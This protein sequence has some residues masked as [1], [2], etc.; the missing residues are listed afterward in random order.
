MKKNNS[1]PV[2][3][4]TLV[5]RIL[6]FVRSGLTVWLFPVS[7]VSDQLNAVLA[8]PNGFRKLLAEGS[9]GVNYAFRFA[10]DR[11]SSSKIPGWD[12]FLRQAAWS[13]P[14]FA[15]L[16]LLAP[17]YVA[18]FFPEVDKNHE[19]LA[20]FRWAFL[21]IPLSALSSVPSGFL[22]SRRENHLLI[23]GT[24]GFSLVTILGLFLISTG[25]I[26]N[27]G[28]FIALGG[29]LQLVL[30][31][32]L[33]RCWTWASPGKTITR[34]LTR[35]WLFQLGFAATPM[36]LFLVIQILA[37]RSQN[38][39][40]LTT[41]SIQYNLLQMPVGL[42]VNTHAMESFSEGLHL[43]EHSAFYYFRKLANLIPWFIVLSVA[44]F[45]FEKDVMQFLFSSSE[46]ILSEEKLLFILTLSVPAI[47]FSSFIQK[48]YSNLG[49]FL[50]A[51]LLQLLGITLGFWISFQHLGVAWTFSLTMGSIILAL[52]II[53]R[54]N[55]FHYFKIV[56]IVFRSI[57]YS[58]PTIV[59]LM[60]I[61]RLSFNLSAVWRVLLAGSA[62]LF[63]LI[64]PSYIL[65][66]KE[67]RFW[68]D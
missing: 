30:L 38:T 15:V 41:L 61:D 60:V 28:L 2:I 55:L 26:G 45:Y 44:S 32:V 6:G 46:A 53:F 12:Y 34:G 65:K 14:S 62:C 4:L 21:Y 1:V 42:L 13:L 20:S 64:V 8:M 11:K 10:H 43:G 67:V 33:A 49:Q 48:Y 39:G 16:Y 25:R 31:L 52:P 23:L 3:F 17:I 54:K 7:S 35:E 51:F 18:M 5:S 58:V 50:S 40:L 59:A 24:L 36:I 27:W 29:M 47:A 37:S 9:L 22:A 19:V 63:F 57:F 68:E 66:W 56:A